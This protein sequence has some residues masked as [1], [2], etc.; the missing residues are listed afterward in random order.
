MGFILTDDVQRFHDAAWPLLAARLDGNVIASV[1]L[2][3]LEGRY[4]DVQTWFAYRSNDSGHAVTAALRTAP[5]PML[6]TALGPGEAEL[7]LDGWMQA[8]RGLPGINGLPQ[9]ARSLAAAWT[10]RTGGAA[11]VVR[12]MAMHAVSEVADAPHRPEGGLRLARP[13]ER[14]LLTEWWQAFAREAGA[15]STP[16]FAERQVQAR[17]AEDG[18]FV[19]NDGGPVSLVAISPPVG[20]VPRIGPVYTP[21]EHRRRGY[22]GTAV[23]EVSRRALAGGAPQVTLFTDLANPTAN[24]IYAEVGYRRFGD[25]EEHAF[26]PRAAAP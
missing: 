24:K 7:L 3:A 20:G 5:F 17:L 2:G 8:D 10:A 14:D 13:Q 26:H 15:V 19:W 25:W 4:D 1:L 18:A 23:A 22:A 6:C 21:P 11:T 9:T 16:V 12:S